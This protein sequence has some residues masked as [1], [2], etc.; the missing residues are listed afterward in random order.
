MYKLTPG[1]CLNYI[2]GIVCTESKAYQNFSCPYG[3]PKKCPYYI[4]AT[5]EDAKQ[6]ETTGI[7]IREAKTI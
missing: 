7:I 2:N 6:Y 3:D 1:Q 5:A 4:P